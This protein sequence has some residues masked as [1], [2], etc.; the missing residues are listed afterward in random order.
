MK[1]G[2][3]I[4]VNFPFTDFDGSKFRPAVVLIPENEYGDVCLCFITSRIIDNEDSIII[5]EKDKDF[6]KTGLKV[7]SVVRVGKIVVLEKKMI[8]GKI[9]SL[10]ESHIKSI[11]KILKKIFQL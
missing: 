9:G 1:K 4:L 11:N 10:S 6:R 5:S 8:A 3:V 2:D 7:S